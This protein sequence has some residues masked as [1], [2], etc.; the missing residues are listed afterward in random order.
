MSDDDFLDENLDLE[1]NFSN[2]N[3]PNSSSNN[4]SMSLSLVIVESP[5]KIKK[6]KSYLGSNYIVMAS[7]G[8]IMDL[9]M[10][11]LGI[12]L[13]TLEPT[14]ETYPDKKK[15]V[16]NIKSTIKQYNIK[17]IYIAADGDREGEFIGYSLVKLLGLNSFKRIIFHEITKTA[18]M[19]AIK[20]PTTLNNNMIH[21]QQSRRIMDRL[22]GFLISPILYKNV[23]GAKSAGR[24]QSVIIK[25]I[26]SK[27]LEREEF[28]KNNDSSYFTGN[29]I[30][31]LTSNDLL[32]DSKPLKLNTKMYICN[33]N[34][35]QIIQTNKENMVAFFELIK[36][37]LDHTFKITKTKIKHLT[38]NPPYPFITS[39]LQQDAFYKFRFSPDKTMKLAQ[40]LYEKGYI[41]YM[42]TD[43]FA[44]SQ[45]AIY[46]IKD[47]IVQNYGI[48]YL[49]VRQYKS[50][51]QNAQEAHE[52]IR[53]SDI[54]IILLD[55]ISD[56]AIKL[57]KLIWERTVASQMEATKYIVMDIYIDLI[58]KDT[59]LE[60]L[61]VFILSGSN[62]PTF[63]GS[64]KKVSFLGYKKIN[65]DLELEKDTIDFNE[66]YMIADK[67]VIKFIEM[68]SSEQINSSLPLYNEPMLIK[69][70]EKYNIGRPSTY[71]S[72]LKKIIDYKYVEIRN[73]EG[74]SKKI[75]TIK[76][77]KKN[78]LILSDKTIVVGSEKQKLITTET[79]KNLVIYLN[80]NFPNIMDYKMTINMERN[81]DLIA[82]GSLDHKTF[83][84]EFYNEL[85]KWL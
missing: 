32:R 25:M 19:K 81:L 71:A 1:G 2:I 44:I 12:N 40:Q 23:K 72:L 21:A 83:I 30:F 15:V 59:F 51:N 9:P 62:I 45:D 13:D 50:K 35:E 27:Q 63:I 22:I 42:R 16:N 33:S 69:T 41:T 47:Y 36:L 79:G 28:W 66:K 68:N 37:Y 6:I 8:H 53:P 57:Y 77:N 52:C 75:S 29:G 85:K 61:G 14:Y 78:G 17:N 11:T 10:K 60:Q 55:S 56:D 3:T 7:I 24:V 74:L 82:N 49:K 48:E 54:N 46:K 70:L 80:N 31:E 64:I 58:V 67:T 38:N 26:L 18:I 5:G 84:K 34:Y 43:S 73:I 39:T 76:L 4:S 20:E 65:E